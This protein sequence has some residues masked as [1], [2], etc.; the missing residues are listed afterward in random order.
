MGGIVTGAAVVLMHFT[1][2]AALEMPAHAVWDNNYVIASAL[3]GVALP[4]MALHMAR[5]GGSRDMALG[6]GLFTFAVVA[7]HFT[8]MSAVTYV[9]DASHINAAHVINK[10]VLAVV[11]A[12]SAASSSPRA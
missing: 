6:A 1:G 7:M 8:G 3:I 12:A 10:F 2:M 11:V 9:P 5:R 4:G